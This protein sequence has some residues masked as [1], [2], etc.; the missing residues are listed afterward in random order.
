METFTRRT[1]DLVIEAT[2]VGD[3]ETDLQ[4]LA[5]VTNFLVALGSLL[6]GYLQTQVNRTGQVTDLQQRVTGLKN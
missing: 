3:G 4:A 2:S 6:A 1:S 5:E